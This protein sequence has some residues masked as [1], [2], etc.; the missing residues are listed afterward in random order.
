ML[1]PCHLVQRPRAHALGQR[2]HAGVTT[3]RGLEQVARTCVAHGVLAY[4]SM[5][6]IGSSACMRF[7][8]FGLRHA[9]WFALLVL[10]SS[11]PAAVGCGSR[12]PRILDDTEEATASV[13]S[14][15]AKLS[16]PEKI[17]SLIAAVR[18]CNGCIFIQSE[19]PRE[20]RVAAADLERRLSRVPAGIATARQ[21][22]DLVG[23]GRMRAKEADRIKLADGEEVDLREWLLSQLA[24]LEGAPAPALARKKSSTAKQSPSQLGILDALALVERSGLLFV[25]PARETAKGK[26]RGKR[27]E[28][29]STE[30]AEML[31]K[32]WSFIGAD[33]TDLDTFIDEIASEAF[34]SFQPYRVVLTDGSEAEFREWLLQQLDARRQT[35]ATT[36]P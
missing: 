17:R 30:F 12:N 8:G 21:F 23:A 6:R 2:R 3:G 5:S 32:K 16:E 9:R 29:T 28:Y 19:Q 14:D 31:R 20:P 18:A 4:Q 36:S 26:T 24:Q 10:S 34:A 25:A 11:V 27:K 13:R 33:I 7:G 15:D 1:L 22:I 35:L